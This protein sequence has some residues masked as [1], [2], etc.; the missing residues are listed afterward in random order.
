MFAIKSAIYLTLQKLQNVWPTRR[1]NF[2]NWTNQR[3]LRSIK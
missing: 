3:M 2:T 1:K